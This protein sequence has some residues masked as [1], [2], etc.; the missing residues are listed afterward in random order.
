VYPWLVLAAAKLALESPSDPGSLASLALVAVQRWQSVPPE[1][2]LMKQ[3][4]EAE[5][6]G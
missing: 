3:P 1:L 4:A 2:L 6:L 5:F